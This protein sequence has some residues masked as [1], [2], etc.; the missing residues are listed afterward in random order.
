MNTLLSHKHRSALL[1]LLIFVMFFAVSCGDDEPG[2]SAVPDLVQ[3]EYALMSR[4]LNESL[5]GDKVV[6]DQHTSHP[7]AFFWIS[8]GDLAANLSFL[9]GYVP[10]ADS[11]M[12]EEV[13]ALSQDTTLHEP[14]FESTTKDVILLT[15]FV[16]ERIFR[17][18][19][20]LADS[21]EEFTGEFGEDQHLFVLSRAAFNADRTQALIAVIDYYIAPNGVAVA[22]GSLV[23]YRRQTS[24]D[25][26]LLNPEF[27]PV[28]I[29]N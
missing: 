19:R 29:L 28:W 12:I 16:K 13:I 22:T 8:E 24:A 5:T 7:L 27:V 2:E 6:V 3:E 1:A 23:F 20:S 14:L 10:A 11:E 25:E 9:Q 26:W 18:D 4:F 17:P 15:P 21:W